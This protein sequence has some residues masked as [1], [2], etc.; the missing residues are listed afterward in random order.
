MESHLGGKPGDSGT[1]CVERTQKNAL[2]RKC[3]A[4]RGWPCGPRPAGC[5]TEGAAC[6]YKQTGETNSCCSCSVLL[7][8]AAQSASSSWVSCALENTLVSLRHCVALPRGE[9]SR[10]SA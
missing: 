6:T 8:L 4:A 5:R 9:A 3:L 1:L 10:L 7:F 2:P